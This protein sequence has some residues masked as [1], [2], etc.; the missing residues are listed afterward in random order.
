MRW[1]QRLGVN[2]AQEGAAARVKMAGIVW[3]LHSAAQSCLSARP[4]R[5][6]LCD[7]DIPI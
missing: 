2:A 3:T 1:A 6:K 7:L 5:R 4:W